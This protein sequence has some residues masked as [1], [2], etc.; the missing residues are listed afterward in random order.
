[1]DPADIPAIP[2]RIR[3]AFQIITLLVAKEFEQTQKP[4]AKF[5]L[6]T[7]KYF[8]MVLVQDIHGLIEIKCT[9]PFDCCNAIVLQRW[10]SQVKGSQSPKSSGPIYLILLISLMTKVI[11]P[12]VENKIVKSPLPGVYKLVR[13]TS[14]EDPSKGENGGALMKTHDAVV[15]KLKTLKQDILPDGL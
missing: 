9:C 4:G 10:Q 15:E 3:V 7:G 5:A 14:M 2:D 13:G 11:P 12:M 8:S 1:M 6:F